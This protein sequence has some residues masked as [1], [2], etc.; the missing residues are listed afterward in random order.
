[1][2]V[3][4]E[5]FKE[6]EKLSVNSHK[7]VWFICEICGIGV[8]QAYRTYLKQNEGKFCRPCRN[9]HT[10]NRP[11]VK[12]KQSSASKKKW[13][14]PKYRDH[15]S[16]VLSKA[17][18]EAWDQDDGT[19]K[20]RM[21][22]NNPMKDPIIRKKQAE[23]EA[24]SIKELKSI[25]SRYN[26]K[27][28]GRELGHR[29]GQVILYECNKGHIQRKRLDRFR[30]GQ[31][32]CA[33][34]VKSFSLEEKEILQYIKNIYNGLIMENDRT[35]ISPYELDIV[36]PNKKIAI[37]YCGLYWHGEQKG[38]DKNY[39]LN[40]LNLC[41]DKGY[42]LITI[43]SNEW[44]N[45]RSI[46]EKYLSSQILNKPFY[47]EEYNVIPLDTKT[48]MKFM[49]HNHIQG[50]TPSTVRLGIYSEGTLVVVMTFSPGSK[51]GIWELNRFCSSIYIMSGAKK[52]LEY[53]Q[54]NYE[55]DII[56]SYVDRRWNQGKFH[57]K[58]GFHKEEILNPCCFYY[59]LNKCNGHID[60][61]FKLDNMEYKNILSKGWDRIWDCG[62]YKFIMKN[63]KGPS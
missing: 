63:K 17:C 14:D 7:K 43:F 55:W 37:E 45:K 53:F 42:K 16:K 38:K 40:K 13:K 26:Y 59:S 32:R 54:K 31:Y 50:Y 22:D 58:L 10:A 15:M 39:H 46:V 36:I 18:K 33:E 41:E 20:Q 60:T 11:D 5:D 19:R 23:S 3:R 2:L 56:Y 49:N 4:R 9:K 35:L 25:C 51:S 34:C 6:V 28:L 62:N 8:L 48:T 24:V 29:G 47:I 27:Y 12:E 21:I 1:M 57:K 30:V 61:N 52:L 44:L